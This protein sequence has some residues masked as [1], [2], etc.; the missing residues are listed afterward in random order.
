MKSDQTDAPIPPDGVTRKKLG[1]RRL[2][3]L[4][5]IVVSGGFVAWTTA[6]IIEVHAE[7]AALN[8]GKHLEQASWDYLAPCGFMLLIAVGVFFRRRFGWAYALAVGAAIFAELSWIGN[9]R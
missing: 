5:L 7:T 6:R 9:T 1:S 2:P 4:A 3:F 8:P